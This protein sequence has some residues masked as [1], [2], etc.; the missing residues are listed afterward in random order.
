M[1]TNFNNGKKNEKPIGE[2]EGGESIGKLSS[3]EIFLKSVD[4][5]TKRVSGRF[6]KRVCR[7]VTVCIPANRGDV[8]FLFELG[9]SRSEV[10][11]G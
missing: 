3:G 7:G 10:Y 11:V 6:H 8:W 4:R 5:R 9:H 2:T 1:I